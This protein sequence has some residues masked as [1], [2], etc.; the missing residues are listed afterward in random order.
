MDQSPVSL[1]LTKKNIPHREFTHPGP[2]HNLEQ[3]A[4]ER[5]QTIY[6]VIRSILFRL[7]EDKYAM[8]L[9]A[10]PFQVSWQALRKHFNQSRLTMASPDKVIQITGYEIGAV[11]PF[12]LPQPLPIL[13]DETVLSQPSISIGSG[14]KGTTI[15]MTTDNLMNTLGEVEI[16]SFS[17]L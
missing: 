17:K 9:I 11:S 10:G 4:A 5:N 1:I 13:V 16:G 6:Q 3:A 2:I 14:I 12:G 15:L 7:S 8:V